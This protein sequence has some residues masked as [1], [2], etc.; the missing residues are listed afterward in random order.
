MKRPAYAKGFLARVFAGADPFAVYLLYGE[1]WNRRNPPSPMD[2]LAINPREYQP[3][4]IDLRCLRGIDVYLE[5]RGDRWLELAGELAR[6]ARTVWWRADVPVYDGDTKP[7]STWEPINTLALAYRL[8]DGAWP[9]W[10][11]VPNVRKAA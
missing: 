6:E 10:W 11:I 2:F 5:A 7:R 4:A 9:D 3:G 8:T 1:D